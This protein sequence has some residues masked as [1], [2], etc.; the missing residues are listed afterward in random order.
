MMTTTS[1]KQ[2]LRVTIL[3]SLAGA[4]LLLGACT[5]SFNQF[6]ANGNTLQDSIDFRQT[7]H[8]EISSLQE[9]TSCKEEALSMDQNAQNTGN[10]AQY[11]TSADMLLSCEANV[12][13]TLTKQI[14]EDR[15]KNYA[16]AIQNYIKSGDMSKAS[17]ALTKF[18][19]HFSDDLYFA[20]GSSFI[21][22]M[23]VLTAQHDREHIGQF[24]AINI[25][26]K[27]KSEIRRMNYWQ[28][29]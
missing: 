22:T 16:I 24:S 17:Q 14:E 6:G 20:D 10:I 2:A 7:R 27:L 3:S 29:N 1:K 26:E 21:A 9:F 8:A 13:S 15:M 28:N 18:K 12:P 25:D 19:N 4:S 23:E 11:V 5:T